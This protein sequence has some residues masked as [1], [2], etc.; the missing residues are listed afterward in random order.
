M[1]GERA[2]A[3]PEEVGAA[4]YDYLLFSGYVA[5]AYW[6]ASS[7]AAA[8]GA[9]LPAAFIQAKRETARFYFDRILPRTLAHAAAID[10]GAASLLTLPPDRFDAK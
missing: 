4:A 3:S 2:A 10:S 7:A 6:W 9:P 5:L 8:E 1:V